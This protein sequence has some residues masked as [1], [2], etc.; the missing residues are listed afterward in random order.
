MFRALSLEE[1]KCILESFLAEHH[2]G[3]GAFPQVAYAPLRIISATQ[4][5]GS[6]HSPQSAPAPP[7]PI[8]Q[9]KSGNSV[10]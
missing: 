9:E 4:H 7:T 1:K 6:Q 10:R 2:N 3:Q 8:V 5:F